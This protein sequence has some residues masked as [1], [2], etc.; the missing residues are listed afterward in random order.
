V[1]VHDVTEIVESRLKLADA[2]KEREIM[3][4]E[5]H[6]RVKNNLQIISSLLNMQLR[7]LE[8]GGARHAVEDCRRRVLVIAQIHERLYLSK[9]YVHIQLGELIQPLVSDI[10]S[11]VVVHPDIR[12]ELAIDEV[13]LDLARAIPCALLINELV[14]NA[15]K[16]AFH[17]RSAGTVRVAF[18]R[19]EPGLELEVADDG[20]GLPD[21]FDIT[22]ASSMG[23]QLIVAL[24]A[25]LGGML[26]VDSSTGTR[27][28]LTLPV[29]E[30][31]H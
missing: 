20:C 15:L 3:L 12:F 11:S 26:A 7:R 31:Q 29:V 1:L 18:R 21:G 14:T 30:S 19:R 16:H 24:A 23:A 28:Q 5:I 4:Q 17:G 13:S 27:F 8:P 2:V 25:Q 6:H 9:D 22:R 10:F